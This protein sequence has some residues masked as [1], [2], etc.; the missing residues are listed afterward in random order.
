MI[1][2]ASRRTDIP[3]YYSEWLVNRLRAGFVLTRNP[4]NH[5]RVSRI[6]LSP[7]VVDCLVLWTKDPQNMLDKLDIIDRLGYKYYFQFTITPYDQSI[8]RGLRDKEEIIKTFRRLSERIGKEKVLWRYDPVI[9]NDRFDQAYH[10]EQFKRFCGRLC[11]FTDSCTVSFADIYPKLRTD[12]L[13]E[14]GE[15]EMAELGG[16]ISTDAKDFGIAV[17]ACCE[18]TLLS[19]C[20]IGQAHCIDRGLIEKICG[21]GLD[22]KRDRN[23]RATC[24]CFESVDIGAYNTCGNGCVYCYANYSRASAENNL[25]RHNPESGLLI[26]DIGDNDKITERRASSNKACRLF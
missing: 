26:G 6:T 13:R 3:A 18:E 10:Q 9:L 17:K 14:I 8:E 11:G 19:K 1:I 2:S 4:M 20:G 15:D 23:Q 21:C 25:K 5:A 24:G 22:I 16:M 7:D 12:I